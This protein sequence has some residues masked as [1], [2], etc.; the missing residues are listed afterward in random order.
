MKGLIYGEHNIVIMD[1]SDDRLVDEIIA[2]VEMHTHPRI[3]GTICKPLDK[4]HP[5][6]KV[7]SYSASNRNFNNAR[8]L[9]EDIH[10]GLCN[11][12]VAV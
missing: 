7:V 8:E 12:D 10:P 6:I 11:F 3:T 1:G 4:D 2:I 9:I 5:T